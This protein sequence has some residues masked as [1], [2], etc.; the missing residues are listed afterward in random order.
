MRKVT[1]AM[2]IHR[3]RDLHDAPKTLLSAG[4]YDHNLTLKM[5]NAFLKAGGDGNEDHRFPLCSVKLALSQALLEISYKDKEAAVA[6]MTV[7]NL[8]PDDICNQ[9]EDL[10]TTRVENG[11]WLPA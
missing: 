3:S 11:T 9:A 8:M 10:Y 5:I 2:C 7:L 4:Q 6:H 1:Q